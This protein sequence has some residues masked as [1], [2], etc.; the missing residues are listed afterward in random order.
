M[1]LARDA[2]VQHLAA[3]GGFALDDLVRDERQ[4]GLQI[5]ERTAHE[6]FDAEDRVLRI[7]ER[8]FA[9]RVAD[10]HGAVV[11]KADAT[12]NEGRLL[13][14]A[15]DTLTL[16]VA[17]KTGSDY[18][19]GVFDNGKSL[20]QGQGVLTS[21]EGG[22]RVTS[23]LGDEKIKILFPADNSGDYAHRKIVLHFSNSRK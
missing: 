14:V 9:S 7:A 12:G 6:P 10:K 13:G 16:D 11:V 1:L 19:L 21:V 22:D 17:G 23:K 3:I 4:F 8:P 20:T 15:H 18:E 5:S 2:D